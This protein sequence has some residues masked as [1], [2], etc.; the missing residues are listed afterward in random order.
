TT[1]PMDS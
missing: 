1:I